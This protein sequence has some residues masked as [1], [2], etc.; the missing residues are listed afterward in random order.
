MIAEPAY[1]PDQL[2]D[3]RRFLDILAHVPPEKRDLVAIATEAF[4][5]GMDAQERLQAAP[6]PAG[7]G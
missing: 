2:R 4:A 5:R 3:A 1:A 6:A 7:T